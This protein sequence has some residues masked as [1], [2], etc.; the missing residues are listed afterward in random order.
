MRKDRITPSATSVVVP[1]PEQIAPA[2]PPEAPSVLERPELSVQQRQL[3]RALF[4]RDEVLGRIYA[5]GLAAFYDRG[6]PDQ[7]ALHAQAMREVMERLSRVLDV[8]AKD[9]HGSLKDRANKL[10]D[11]WDSAC[12]NSK[13]L[14]RPDRQHAADAPAGAQV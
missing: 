11:Q 1:S 14:A 6:N 13:M 5:G 9:S 4:E 12:R 10:Q 8:P 2:N 7:L 3:L